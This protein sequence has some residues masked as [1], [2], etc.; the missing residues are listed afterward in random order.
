[1]RG[2]A[3]KHGARVD[4]AS[5]ESFPASDPPSW[6]LGTS[7]KGPSPGPTPVPLPGSVLRPAPLAQTS[8]SMGLSATAAATPR[9]RSWW[10]RWRRWD[11]TLA[12]AGGLGAAAA[13]TLLAL[14]RKRA[15]RSLAHASTSLFLAAIFARLSG[16]P[17][18]SPRGR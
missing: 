6:T 1:M 12:V 7:G 11:A 16:L 9:A 4:E 8:A 14:G 18:A 17:G 2:E 5:D 10:S 13:S 15:G 3:R